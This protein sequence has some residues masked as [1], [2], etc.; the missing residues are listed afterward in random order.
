M[1]VKFSGNG[2]SN[3]KLINFDLKHTSQ[4]LQLK[5]SCLYQIF[6]SAILLQEKKN[7]PKMLSSIAVFLY[8][9]S[10]NTNILQSILGLNL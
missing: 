1:I 4:Q 8:G 7:L 6:S 10:Q 5:A 9:R 2:S 3:E